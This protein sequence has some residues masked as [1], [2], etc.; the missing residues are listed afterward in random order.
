[1][2]EA[3]W[4]TCQTPRKM[5]R[6]L[7][8]KLFG[9][10]HTLFLT[11]IVQ[12]LAEHLSPTARSLVALHEQFAEREIETAAYREQL[13]ALD[14]ADCQ[15]LDR[16]LP[17]SPAELAAHNVDVSIFNIL[18]ALK[19]YQSNNSLRASLE[20]GTLAAV[21]ATPECLRPQ[22]RK[23]FQSHACD[24]LRELFPPLS[25]EYVVQPDFVGGGLLMPDG[26]TFRVP[27][28]ARNIALGVQRDQAFDRLPILADALEDAHCPDRPLLDHLR[29]G[30]NHRRGCWAL[31]LVLGRG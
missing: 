20:Y 11:G 16:P 6:A 2:T 5:I 30:T 26:T 4:L 19:S 23:D 8:T 31:D 3:E 28:F 14:A 22:A 7:G 25:R 10:R 9:R 18:Q 13:A 15:T 21:N 12:S 1:M 17:V 29:H 27:E 24:L